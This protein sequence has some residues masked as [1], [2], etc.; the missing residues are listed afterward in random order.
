MD[1]VTALR[2]EQK[3]IP[4]PE[5]YKTAGQFYAD[6]LEDLAEDFD[7][8]C[9]TS[10]RG[11]AKAQI[12]FEKF[13]HAVLNIREAAAT[14]LQRKFMRLFPRTQKTTDIEHTSE[15]ENWSRDELIERILSQRAMLD[16]C[17]DYLFHIH[18]YA[19]EEHPEDD[20]QERYH[21]QQVAKINEYYIGGYDAYLDDMEH[22]QAELEEKTR[23][24]YEEY[25][26]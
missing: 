9:C 19:N 20:E 13:Q 14:V 21:S 22:E 5:N 8:E 4:V 16:S 23:H 6:K 18:G 3:M 24:A 2:M 15:F 11:A 10:A 1:P 26:E 17:A 12:R 25:N 7:D